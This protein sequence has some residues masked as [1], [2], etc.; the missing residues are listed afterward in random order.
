M[1]RI[2][3]IFIDF[4]NVQ[5]IELD[6]I[7]DKPVKVVI[8]LGA[9]HKKLPVPLVKKLHQYA[10]AVQLV[11]TGGHGK[12][13]LDLVL[14]SYMGEAKKTDPHGYFHILSKDK[15]F[16][17]VIGHYKANGILAARH[18][19]ISEIRVLMNKDERVKFISTRFQSKQETHAKNKA[20]LES[21]IQAWFGKAL[22]AAELKET[23]NGLIA[24]KAIKVA[25]S[26]DVTY[27][28]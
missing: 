9:Q 22:S 14:A 5:E 1:T 28:A 18:D 25:V 24:V 6:R 11:E 15:D 3:Y 23:I 7:A 20:K 16:D 13:A 26:G 17:A 12:N 8:V 21:Q 27:K 19:S 10:N 2:N 4:E